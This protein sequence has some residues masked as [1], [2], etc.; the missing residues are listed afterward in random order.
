M[1]KNAKVEAAVKAIY[2]HVFRYGPKYAED[3]Y[4]SGCGC[5]VPSDIVEGRKPNAFNRASTYLE[6]TYKVTH[7]CVEQGLLRFDEYAELGAANNEDL[8]KQ[9][10]LQFS[11]EELQQY[12]G[13]VE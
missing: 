8:V 11:V 13:K 10:V 3:H 6:K 7:F 9:G 12:F 2:Q 4:K 1:F 5:L